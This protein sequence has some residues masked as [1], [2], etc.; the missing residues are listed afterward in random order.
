M[1]L[2]PIPV[3][4]L[5]DR[6]GIDIL[7]PIKPISDKGF[8]YVLVCTEYLSKDCEAHPLAE[9][10]A[11]TVAKCFVENVICRWGCPRHLLSDRGAQFL[12]DLVL[13]VCKLLSINKVT[14]CSYRPQTNG[15]TERQNRILANMLS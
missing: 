15:Q 6:V 11:P 3:E 13:E 14:T 4:G 9:I 10:S 7:G 1:P 5:N 12:S 2:N 8:R